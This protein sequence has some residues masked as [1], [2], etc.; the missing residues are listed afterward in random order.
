MSRVIVY[1]EDFYQTG[2]FATREFFYFILFWSGYII[3][4]TILGYI[5]RYYIAD[6]SALI[7]HNHIAKKYVENVYAMSLSA[8][9]QK[10]T[11]SIYKNFNRGTDAHFA[12]M[13]FFLKDVIKTLTTLIV[14]LALLIYTDYRMTLLALSMVPCMG[15]MA[16]Y[17]Y[18][19]TQ[20][21]QKQN[22]IRW[23]RAFGHI[24]DFM[25]NIQLGKI[26]LLEKNFFMRFSTELDEALVF[27]K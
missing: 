5:H 20:E 17:I 23:N 16:F 6:L 27:Q 4:S 26:L 13:F 22:E 12:I 3:V 11:G 24:G 7:F 15:L 9:L 8:Y 2:V 19:K 21:P 1:I 10:K 18:R 14:V 25:S